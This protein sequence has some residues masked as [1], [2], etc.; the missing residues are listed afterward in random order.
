MRWLPVAKTA[1]VALL[2]R[3]PSLP[4]CTH[5]RMQPT[6][7]DPTR[8]PP[9]GLKNKGKSAKVQKYVEQLQKSVQ[10]QRNTRTEE[11]SRKD[12]KKA[13]EERQKELNELFAMA[14]KQ[15]KVC[16]GRATGV[17]AA[18]GRRPVLCTQAGTARQA[19]AAWLCPCSQ[20]PP[21]VSR[22]CPPALIPSPLSASSTSTAS[23]PRASSASSGATKGNRF[24]AAVWGWFWGQKPLASVR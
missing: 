13:E 7:P 10:P 21:R 1:L 2:C 16:M 23:V 20:P 18:R 8:R 9:P 15:P 19:E 17:A 5:R 12:K 11:A 22:R 6:Q 3:C 4:G 24:T 14:I